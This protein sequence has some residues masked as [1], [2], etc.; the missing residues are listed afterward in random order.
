MTLEVHRAD[1]CVIITSASPGLNRARAIS[2]EKSASPFN[3]E[4]VIIL[5]WML[6]G[7]DG[8]AIFFWQKSLQKR[9]A[10]MLDNNIACSLRCPVQESYQSV[11]LRVR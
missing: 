3:R 9:T 1:G 6:P 2:P 10:G 8:C 11:D 4:R 7:M 5:D